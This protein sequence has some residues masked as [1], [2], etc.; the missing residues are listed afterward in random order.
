[1]PGPIFLGAKPGGPA[2]AAFLKFWKKK[3]AKESKNKDGHAEPVSIPKKLQP[4]ESL[5][6]PGKAVKKIYP[7]GIEGLTGD[8]GRKGRFGISLAQLRVKPA[9]LMKV[10]ERVTH[11]IGESLFT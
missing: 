1:L 6:L 7:S 10:S 5:K 9:E 2:T 3:A 4:D 11:S 8:V